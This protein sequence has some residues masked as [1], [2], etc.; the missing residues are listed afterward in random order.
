[1]SL[2]DALKIPSA[3]ITDEAVYR[4]RRRLLAGLAAA[5]ALAM[6]GCSR[7][8]PPP[9]RAARIDPAGV[10]AGFSTR[11]ERTTFEDASTYNNF[12]SASMP[13]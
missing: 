8:E 6:A 9:P 11:E 4:D 1:M 13:M 2:R 5:P 7:A 3:Q 10:R 12:R